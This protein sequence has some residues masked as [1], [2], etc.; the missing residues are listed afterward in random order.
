[1]IIIYDNG[2]ETLDRYTIFYRAGTKDKN[3]FISSCHNG[4]SVYLHDEFCGSVSQGIT[5][6]TKRTFLGKRV[7]LDTLN[8]GL[9]QL[10]LKEV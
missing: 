7:S 10:I 8:K 5:H 2:G 9:Q 3:H 6:S 1:M 4:R